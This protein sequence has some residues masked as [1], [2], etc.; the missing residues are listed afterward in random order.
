LNRRCCGFTLL[1]LV[2]LSSALAQAQVPLG[3]EFQV[4]TYTNGYQFAPSVDLDAD[5]D[6]VVVWSS[7]HDGSVRG[8]FGRRFASTG[9]PLAAEFQVNSRTANLQTAASVAS[10]SA[11][12]F[13]VSW[14]SSEQDGQGYG[15]FARRWSASGTALAAE[16]QVN[17][18]TAGVQQRALLAADTDGDFVAVWE[19]EGMGDASGVFGRRFDSAGRP[20]GSEFRVN[21]VTLG[22]QSQAAIGMAA[23]GDFVVAWSSPDASGYGVFARRFTSSG[24]AA[25][26]E[27]QVNTSVADLESYPTLTLDQDGDFV[28]A[29]TSQQGGAVTRVFARRFDSSGSPSGA[30]FRVDVD[31]SGDQS[32]PAV[33]FDAGGDL[34]IVWDSPRDAGTIGLFAQRFES[35]GRAVGPA[36]QV[37]TYVTGTQYGAAIGAGADGD[38]VVVWTSAEQDGSGYGVFGRRFAAPAPR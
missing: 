27:F 28:I 14:T 9:V 35:P 18:Y 2:V 36:R 24:A 4:S 13:V 1:G 17:S 25:G 11:G 7:P 6:F 5:G 30:E 34:V 33:A 23:R 21:S 32:Q 19:G 29:W 31:A 37:N 10:T 16:F 26:P 20:Q 15:I 22:A 12:A 38:F 3:L 8:V